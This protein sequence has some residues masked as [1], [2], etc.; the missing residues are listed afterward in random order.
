MPDQ[1]RAI[2]VT[3]LTGFLGAGKT[4]LLNHLIH[5]PALADAAVLINEFG[6]I[7]VDHHLVDKVDDNIVVLDSGCLCCSVRGDLAR[8]LRDLFMRR[9]RREIPAF[10]RVLIET[11]GLADPA[12]VL[13][14]LLE[15]FFI[16]ERYRIDGVVTAVDLTHANGQLSRHFE[17]VKQVTMADRLL[18]TKCDLAT[19]EE[20]A[21]V[22]RRLTRA[23]PGAPQIEVRQGVIDAAQ[24]MG[25]GL[26]DPTSK[27]ADVGRWLAEEKVRSVAANHDTH[28]HA[29]QAT[30]PRAQIPLGDDPNRHD[31]MVQAFVLRFDQP[32]V[33]PE[34]TEAI[35][36]LLATCGDRILR[37]KGLI[38]IA[39][40]NTPRVVQCVQHMR[41]PESALPAWPDDDHDSRLVFIVRALAREHV[42]KAFAMFCDAQAV[43]AGT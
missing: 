1:S 17:A 41:Y 32:F 29:P 4:T 18:L 23:N 33:W 26:Y 10:S 39:G 36:V 7:G 19:L 31:A 9:L 37:V 24:I 13:Y 12:P 38:N 11:T 5:Q 27:N 42:E 28:P 2:P 6:E 43:E 30:G 15:D 22:A 25:C 16:A 35:D 34:F 8:S 20:I 3:V 14:T 21:V 40:E